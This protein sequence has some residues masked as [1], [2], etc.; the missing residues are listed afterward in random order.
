MNSD[1]V[2]GTALTL[3]G[4]LCLIVVIPVIFA[5]VFFV[6]FGAFAILGGLFNAI[7]AL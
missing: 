4:V 5:V 1:I 2:Q 7:G 3:K 6:G